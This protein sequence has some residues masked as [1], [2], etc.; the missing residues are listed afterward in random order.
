MSNVTFRRR[1]MSRYYDFFVNEKFVG[2]AFPCYDRN[3]FVGYRVIEFGRDGKQINAGKKIM[4][5]RIDALKFA[6]EL[7]SGCN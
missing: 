6:L 1:K 7:F 5:S 4:R 2:F 3:S